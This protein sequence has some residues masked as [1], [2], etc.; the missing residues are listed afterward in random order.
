MVPRYTL[1]AP[2]SCSASSALTSPGRRTRSPGLE[3]LAARRVEARSL[4][5]RVDGSERLA[6]AHGVCRR[7]LDTRVGEPQRRLAQ[8]S[9]WEA[10]VR[11]PERI[12]PRREAGDA[13]RRGT[14]EIRD[15]FAP[16]RHVD[17]DQHVAGAA[18]HGD[19]AV[20]I[21]H[22]PG[23]RFEVD[24]EA[25]A[26]QARHRGFRDA[27]RERR[28]DGRVG[29]GAA[30]GEDLGADLC[31]GVVPSRDGTA[32][33]VILTGAEFGGSLRRSAATLPRDR[34]LARC[35]LGSRRPALGLRRRL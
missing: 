2:S 11:A 33:D 17:L 4:V 6:Q 10:S 35:V 28:S 5:H 18:R 14:D 26:E 8:S 23:R 15:G 3:Q 29:G 34:I 22:A 25:A 30:L 7:E 1:C 24:R 21:A 12:E 20:E 16:E 31:R 13:E 32:H 27:R 19:E 9:P